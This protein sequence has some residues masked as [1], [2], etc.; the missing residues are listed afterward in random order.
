LKLLKI[1]VSLYSYTRKGRVFW[2][3][4]FHELQSCS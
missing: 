2:K 4:Q 1:I 3:L